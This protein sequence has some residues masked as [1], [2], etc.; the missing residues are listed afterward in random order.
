MRLLPAQVLN[1]MIHQMLIIKIKSS[2]QHCSTFHI[3]MQNY[4]WIITLPK[5]N[6]SPE[7]RPKPKKKVFQPCMFN[8]FQG[9]LHLLFQGANQPPSCQPPNSQGRD[10]PLEVIGSMVIGS[11]GFFTPR[12]TPFIS[13]WN[14]PLILTMD[15][16]TSW[17]IFTNFLGHPTHRA[18]SL[19]H[20]AAPVPSPTSPSTKRRSAEAAAALRSPESQ[21][22][23]K[24]SLNDTMGLF[25]Q[26]D[27]GPHFF[28]IKKHWPRVF[29]AKGLRSWALRDA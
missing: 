9:F 24:K 23:S 14:N 19:H 22:S 2:I 17:D 20:V 12:N 15:P 18:K 1:W 8:H 7:N 4:I 11:V 27:G 28:P 21:S 29:F 3:S 5:T 16:F 6:I 10:V 26:W 25:S 13:R